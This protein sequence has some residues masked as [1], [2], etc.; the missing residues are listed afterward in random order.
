MNVYNLNNKYLINLNNKYLI[1]L[2]NKNISL[3]M[4]YNF[5]RLQL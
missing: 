5:C 3:I 1:N 2:N 4:K